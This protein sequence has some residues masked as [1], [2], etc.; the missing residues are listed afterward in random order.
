MA[1]MSSLTPPCG[2][3]FVQ[4]GTLI[5]NASKDAAGDLEELRRLLI[6]N[7][8]RFSFDNLEADDIFS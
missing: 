7:S 2:F 3:N 8:A 1:T 4:V 6:L 5:A